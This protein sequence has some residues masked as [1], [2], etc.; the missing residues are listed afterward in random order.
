MM[1]YLTYA[2]TFTTLI[3]GTLALG[4]SL[5]Q[6]CINVEI[7]LFGD[8][9]NKVEYFGVIS[10]RT[11]SPIHLLPLTARNGKFYLGGG[12]PSSY[13]PENRCTGTHCPLGNSTVFTG[14]NVTLDLG[15]TIKGGQKVYVADDGALSYTSASSPVI[16]PGS[17]GDQF[18][19]EAPNDQSFG[20]LLFEPSSFIACPAVSPETGYQVFGGTEIFIAGP[21]CLSFTAL[22]REL[23]LL[24][25]E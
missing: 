3:A 5:G 10:S 21:E 6:L 8:P 9:A 15:V 16:P 2:S 25:K 18:S 12:P 22:I 17:Y 19:K 24:Y 13:C 11:A 23:H 7:S 4:V 1:R 20:Y 14:G